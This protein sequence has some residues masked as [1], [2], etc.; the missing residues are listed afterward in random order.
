MSIRLVGELLTAVAS[1]GG[2]TVGTNLFGLTLP[3][4]PVVCTV[5]QLYDGPFVASNPTHQ[6]GFTILHRN[7]H[8]DSG[9][10]LVTSIHALLRDSWNILPTI[11]GRIEAVNVPNGYVY[12]DQNRWAYFPLRFVITSTQP[13]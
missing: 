6:A 10:T 1:L 7:T 12:D 2:G 4:S 11:T 8:V 3:V 9:L 5:V 13:I